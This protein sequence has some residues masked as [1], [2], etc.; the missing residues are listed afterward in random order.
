M[1]LGVSLLGALTKSLPKSI[2]VPP[3]P[4]SHYHV[5]FY[6]GT[7]ISYI[8]RDQLCQFSGSKIGIKFAFYIGAIHKGR[9]AKTRI[10]RPPSPLRSDKTIELNSNNNGTSGFRRPPLPRG[11]PDVLCEWP[12]SI[13]S[14]V[15]Y[16]PSLSHQNNK[17]EPI[18]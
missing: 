7:L 13:F 5:I 2:F 4:I 8:K 9:P 12:L 14:L 18:I 10:S 17:K 6:F 3:P 11:Q 15:C 1:S 16:F